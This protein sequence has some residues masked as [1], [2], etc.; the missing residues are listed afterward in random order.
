MRSHVR[1]VSEVVREL[2]RA[3]KAR[4]AFAKLKN[5]SAG[6]SGDLRFFNMSRTLSRGKIGPDPDNFGR[7][8][9]KTPGGRARSTTPWWPWLGM[10]LRWRWLGIVTSFRE[11][12]IFKGETCQKSGG[13]HHLGKRSMGKGKAA[14]E[15]RFADL[16]L[17]FASISVAFSEGWATPF[18]GL[19]LMKN[20]RFLAGRGVYL[21]EGRGG[22]SQT[23]AGGRGAGLRVLAGCSV[24]VPEYLHFS[25][26]LH[27][28]CLPTRVFASLLL[29]PAL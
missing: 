4:K 2:P 29:F 7:S 10:R 24:F 26:L 22:V 1:T 13:F 15:R 25:E 5:E 16:A 23:L 6:C 8:C 27:S 21:V 3:N 18:E 11:D 28:G 17:L 14:R 12:D 19:L 9:K 20:V